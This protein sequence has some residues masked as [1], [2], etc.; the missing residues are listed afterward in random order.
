MNQ[1]SLAAADEHRG[2]AWVATAILSSLNHSH[3][4]HLETERLAAARS[5]THSTIEASLPPGPEGTDI[6]RSIVA[7][8]ASPPHVWEVARR[9]HTPTPF[10]SARGMSGSLAAQTE[11]GNLEKPSQLVLHTAVVRRDRE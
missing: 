9:G 6:L 3:G 4:L 7:P 2:T 10:H 11:A 5:H 8:R 1:A